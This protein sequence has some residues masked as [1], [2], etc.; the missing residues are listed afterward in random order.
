MVIHILYLVSLLPSKN[1]LVFAYAR[2]C[3]N[4][5]KW[6]RS[7]NTT[8]HSNTVHWKHATVDHKYAEIPTRC[9]CLLSHT[10]QYLCRPHL[11]LLCH[12]SWAFH[13][14]RTDHCTYWTNSTLA[15]NV[16]GYHNAPHDDRKFS[17]SMHKQQ[18]LR[19]SLWLTLCTVNIILRSGF[20]SPIK[21]PFIFH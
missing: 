3:L 19:F 4:R 2:G 7:K 11:C 6:Q 10:W 21:S 5:N 14:R 12:S 15:L 16:N 20:S 1:G 9:N 8:T 17:I 18:C 13:Q